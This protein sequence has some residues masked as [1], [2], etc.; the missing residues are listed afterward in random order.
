MAFKVKWSPRT[1]SNLEE[2]CNYIAKDSEY[3]AILFAKKLTIIVKT[4][5]QFPKSGRIIPEYGDES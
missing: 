4:I 3:Y 2:I 5:P 1:V